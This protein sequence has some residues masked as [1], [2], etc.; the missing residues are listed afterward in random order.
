MKQALILS[1][2][3]LALAAGIISL[4]SGGT[5]QE[6]SDQQA[7]L[8]RN[9]S[10]DIDSVLA[11]DSAVL[12]DVR[13]PEEYNEAHFDGAILLPLQEIEAGAQ[14]SVDKNKTIYL[15]CRSGNRSAD[16]TKLLQSQ[17]YEVVDLGGID[18]VLALGGRL[19][20]GDCSVGDLVCMNNAVDG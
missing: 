19:V 16:A 4:N 9:E 12:L 11:S 14:P 20:P 1:A 8:T 3:I 17:S 15:Y 7:E 2:I 18:D 10:K 13:T 5:G 6:P